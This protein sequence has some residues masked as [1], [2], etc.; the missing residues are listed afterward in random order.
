MQRLTRDYGP[1]WDGY[2]CAVD[3]TRVGLNAIASESFDVGIDP[4]GGFTYKRAGSATA[5]DVFGSPA[6]LLESK[7]TA[8]ARDIFS[9]K[10]RSFTDGYGNLACFYTNDATL[11]GALYFRSSNGGG[12]NQQV[13]KSYGDFHRSR[14]SVQGGGTAWNQQVE[15]LWCANGTTPFTRLATAAQR[16][17]VFPG[18]RKLLQVGGRVY[19]SNRFGTPVMWNGAFNDATGS[20]TQKERLRPMGPTGSVFPVRRLSAAQTTITFAATAT[21]SGTTLVTVPSTAGIL[22]GM[23]VSA[24]GGTGSVAAGTTVIQPITPTTFTLSAAGTN[25]TPA[26]VTLVGGA[27]KGTYQAYYSIVP[28]YDDGSYGMPYVDPAGTMGLVTVDASNPGKTY[29]SVSLLVPQMHDGVVARIVCRTPWA[30]MSSGS[31]VVPDPYTIKIAGVLNDNISGLFVDTGDDASL[32]D[33]TQ[34]VRFDWIMPPR[35][36]SVW[37]MDGRIVFGDLAP[38]PAAIMLAPYTYV[39]GAYF[40]HDDPTG[41]YQFYNDGATAWANGMAFRYDG[42]YLKFKQ[43]IVPGTWHTDSFSADATASSPTVANQTFTLGDLVNKINSYAYGGGEV[44][45]RA[46]LA[47]GVNGDEPMSSLQAMN[48]GSWFDDDTIISDGTSGNCRVLMGQ[49]MRGWLYFSGASSWMTRGVEPQGVHFTIAG[50]ASTAADIDAP[51]AANAWVGGY[52]CRRRLTD[53]LGVLLGGGS[54]LNGSL[55]VYSK[56]I[57]AIRNIRG[58]KSGVDTDYRLEPWLGLHGG[59]CAT[60]I[61]SSSGIVFYMTRLGLMANDGTQ[62]VCIS[63][64]VWTPHG[65]D[66]AGTGAWKYEMQQCVGAIDAGTDT[67]RFHLSAVNGR[68]FVAFRSSNAVTYP[69][70]MMVYDYSLATDRQGV[71]QLYRAPGKLWAWSAPYRIRASVIGEVVR[72]DGPHIYGA[73]EESYAGY[74]TGDGRIDELETGANDNGTGIQDDVY[75]AMDDLGSARQKKRILLVTLSHSCDQPTDVLMASDNI[76]TGTS[77]QA[78]STGEIITDVRLRPVY[79]VRGPC[80]RFQLRRR[81][82][83]GIADTTYSRLHRARVEYSLLNTVL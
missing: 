9:L 36:R 3:D 79:S 30:D 67:G 34:I 39:S 16:R 47:P 75:L 35:A 31:F 15:P 69:D 60:A 41:P 25:G 65:T 2:V 66:G 27:L 14:A 83:T 57:G 68:L 37:T 53:D 55:V 12:T 62:E 46:V 28:L 4:A 80:S 23:A 74:S 52:A 11:E 8:R 32:V 19:G 81:G 78:A 21:I 54:L 50:P 45:W 1:F 33:N 77:T 22:V 56:G 59:V 72:S 76:G 43:E 5:F 7:F 63:P 17:L 82:K 18:S 38:N 51:Y 42:R 20:G 13:G 61:C 44:A 58:G 26:T 40:D 70:R 71:A 10:S 64:A 49:W 6:G 48:G 73:I 29:S 24:S